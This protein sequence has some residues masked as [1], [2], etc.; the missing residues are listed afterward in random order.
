MR[1]IVLI[2]YVLN[3]L[4]YSFFSSFSPRPPPPPTPFYP[5]RGP[6]FDSHVIN[7]KEGGGKKA[8]A[9]KEVR[10]EIGGDGGVGGGG[11]S[12]AENGLQWLPFSSTFILGHSSSARF[13]QR[14]DGMGGWRD[15]GY[16]RNLDSSP[17][18]FLFRGLAWWPPSLSPESKPYLFSPCHVARAAAL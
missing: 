5:Y 13:C 9:R 18:L 17:L 7:C 3:G 6:E 8:R 11:G 2:K 10:K 16:D 15:V 4:C 12:R 14:W 1:L